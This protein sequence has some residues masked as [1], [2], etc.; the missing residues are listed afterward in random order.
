[1]GGIS[2]RFRRA[3]ILVSVLNEMK[4]HPRIDSTRIG[5]WG[6]S[7]AGYVIP[8]AL[9]RTSDIRF[10]ILVGVAGENGIRQTAFYV[11]QQIRCEGASGEEAA[12]AES[13]VVEVSGA[14]SYED[15]VKY[16]TVLLDKFPL[17]REIDYMAGILPRD[18]WS[19]QAADGEAFYDPISVIGQTTI[20]T[21]VFLGEKDKN[22][23]PVQSVEA[24]KAAL[25][26]A[27]NLNY[28][29]EFIPG[30]DHNIIMCE[31]GCEK[32]RRNRSGAEWSNYAPEY[33]QKMESWL[34]EL[35]PQKN[36]TE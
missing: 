11:S 10:M 34:R 2:S 26:R 33:L 15:Y 29:V 24:Y 17:V 1:M 7:Q 4:R 5:V 21:L 31:T 16:G 30:A 28:G 3:D 36:R 13:L 6:V 32:E 35:Y 23:N 9:T 27:G 25:S 8:M 22:V 14:R 20:P 19:P 12:L 18:R